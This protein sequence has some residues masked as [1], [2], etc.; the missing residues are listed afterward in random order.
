M[1]SFPGQPDKLASESLNKSEFPKAR[2]DGVVVAS[3]GPY[4]NHPTLF[5]A[6]NYA[7]IP[8]L[9]FLQTRCSS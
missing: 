4:A 6:D 8:S 3:A 9:N 2:D 7:N 1:A 5:Q